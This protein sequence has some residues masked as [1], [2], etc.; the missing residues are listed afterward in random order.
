MV[1]ISDF[2]MEHVFNK[3]VTKDG[4]VIYWRD[5]VLRDDMRP[6]EQGYMVVF[7]NG[8]AHHTYRL[9]TTWIY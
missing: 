7:A 8:D 3:I 6:G 1:E 5:C 9:P 2:A 4:D